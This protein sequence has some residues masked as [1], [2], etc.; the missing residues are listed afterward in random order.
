LTR[1]ISATAAKTVLRECFKTGEEPIAIVDRLDLWLMPTEEV[2][3]HVKDVVLDHLE[4]CQQIVDGKPQL[5]NV[6][7]GTVMKRTRGKAQAAD[8]L[9][10][11]KGL[12][13]MIWDVELP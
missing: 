2:V 10:L 12:V 9:S 5:L 3:Q 6:L 4:L 11:V 7:V 1:Q 8:V 13:E